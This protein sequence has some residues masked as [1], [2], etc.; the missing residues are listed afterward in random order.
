MTVGVLGSRQ[1][2]LPKKNITM[3]M[4]KLSYNAIL[5]SYVSAALTLHSL[6]FVIRGKLVA[7]SSAVITDGVW[8]V[9]SQDLY[10]LAYLLALF[11]H[12]PAILS[13]EFS[14]LD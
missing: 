13:R 1:F 10:L 8:Y 9:F 2:S 7:M 3:H 5:F 4:R 14:V 11:M 6:G 12:F